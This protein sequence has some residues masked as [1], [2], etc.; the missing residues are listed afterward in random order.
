MTREQTIASVRLQVPI[1]T[2]GLRRRAQIL[3]EPWQEDDKCAMLEAAA[4][5]EKMLALVDG[6]GADK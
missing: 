6:Q 1:T 5:I 3:H 2:K 4:L